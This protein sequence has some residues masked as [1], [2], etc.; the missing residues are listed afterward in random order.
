M[1]N[2]LDLDE[3]SQNCVSKKVTSIAIR[4]TRYVFCKIIETW[5]RPEL[6]DFQLF[7]SLFLLSFVSIIVVAFYIAFKVYGRVFINLEKA[8]DTIPCALVWSFL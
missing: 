7:H 1:L 8:Y 3:N 6:L 5:T 2:H 4:P